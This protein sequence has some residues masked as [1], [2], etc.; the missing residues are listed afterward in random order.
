M[1]PLFG[2]D[3]FLDFSQPALLWENRLPHLDQAEKMISINFRLADSLPQ[4]VLS[5]I[6]AAKNQ[7]LSKFPEPWTA[8]IQRKYYEEVGCVEEKYLENGYGKCWLKY[9][10]IREIIINSLEFYRGERYEIIG[11]VI[12]P[13]HVHLLIMPA[14]G[15]ELKKIMRDLL[16]FTA[17]SINKKVGNKG[18]LWFSDYFDRTIRSQKHYVF[19]VEYMRNNPQYLPE[20]TYSFGGLCFE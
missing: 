17:F 16:H 11:Y 7:F 19:Y 20:G 6:E 12:M 2:K 15:Y 14:N 4:K 10:E 3:A 18:K 8:E 1:I 9:P 5:E 13:N